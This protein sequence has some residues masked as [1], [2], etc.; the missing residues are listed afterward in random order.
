MRAVRNILLVAILV[1]ECAV[2]DTRA[3]SQLLSGRDYPRGAFVEKGI[4]RA[5]FPSV[6]RAVVSDPLPAGSYTVGKSGYFPT[7]DSAFTRL[8]GGGILGPVTL[9]LTDTLYVAP[10]SSGD[11]RLVGPIAGAGPAS[12]IT[13]RPAENVAVT[14]RGSGTA[15][16]TFEDASYV[17]LDG[18]SLQGNT[19]LTVHTVLNTA[20]PWNDAI[21]LWKNCD[22]VVIQNLTASTDDNYRLE[23]STIL[24]LGDASGGPDSCLI[25]GVSVTS[26]PIGIYVGGYM[27]TLRPKGNVIRGCHIGSPT[28]SIISRG[29][30]MDNTEGTVAE[31]NHIE[32]LKHTM[33]F[34]GLTSVLGIHSWYNNNAVIRNNVIHGL[35]GTSAANIHAI[36]GSGEPTQ[37]GQGLR[38]YN[39]MIYDL[40]NTVT[41]GYGSLAGI[42]LWQNNNILVA[43]NTVRLSG[44]GTSPYG[45]DALGFWEG[46]TNVTI[47]NNILVNTCQY[48]APGGAETYQLSAMFIHSAT[49]FTSDYN[50][51]YVDTTY[52]NSWAVRFWNVANH[53]TLSSWQGTGR[54]AHSVSLMVPFRSSTDLHIDTLGIRSQ[55]V[56]LANGGVAV[57]GC[58]YDFDN[59]NRITGNVPDIGADEFWIRPNPPTG[60]ENGGSN[61]PTIYS[62]EQNY[63]N[64][65]NP[66]TTVSY[67]LPV[68]GTIRLAVYDMLGREVCA[69]VNERKEPG[70]YSVT[71][72]AGGMASGV[73]LY[74]LVAGDYYAVRKMLVLR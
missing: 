69:L 54:D 45:T 40:Q 68:A 49:T 9:V 37:V 65:F 23:T 3:L 32:N 19:R 70:R 74:R 36:L 55:W 29:I 11:F 56:P 7:L 6:P 5:D 57:A 1:V 25:S 18:V 47:R 22:N 8:S 46:C 13:I 66:V 35:R 17:T 64:P 26:G 41:I 24:L 39:N 48:Q 4:V 53:R 71:W 14:I 52:A 51:L 42:Q 28:D 34:S 2:T 58:D 43:F 21:D 12:R 60:V 38:I 10:S 15:T 20:Y 33:T 16:L 61:S 27:T 31:N 30:E 63:P 59:D 50:D 67:Q 72:D 73:Y 62:L 44:A